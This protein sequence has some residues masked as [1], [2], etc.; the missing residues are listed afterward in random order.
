MIY[1]HFILIKESCFFKLLKLNA[2]MALEIIYEDAQEDRPKRFK[3][4]AWLKKC[5]CQE[6]WRVRDFILQVNKLASHSF[7]DTGGSMKF[8]DHSKE[9][10]CSTTGSINF[11]F[12]WV[13]LP[14]TSPW[15]DAE[16]DPGK[17]HTQWISITAK[18][19]QF[20][21]TLIFYSGS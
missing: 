5:P 4:T 8:L 10:Y 21:I 11:M 12:A 6:L 1:I 16:I 7:T 17:F 13:P 2:L 20:Q 15:G 14:P 19:T 9:L 18:E 3:E